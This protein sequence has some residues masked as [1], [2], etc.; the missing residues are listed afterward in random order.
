MKFKKIAALLLAGVLCVSAFT[1]CGVNKNATVAT[2]GEQK[3][4]LGIAN[5]MCR[6]EQAGNDD[7][8]LSYFGENAW[9]QDIYGGG[10]TIQDNVKDDVMERL[11][12]YYTMSNH[13]GEYKVELTE[14][15]KKTISDTASAFISANSQDA[16]EELGATQPIVEEMLTLATIRDKMYDAITAEAD[17][18]VSDEE[19]N[20][21]AYTM[22]EMK[23]D[24][25]YDDDYNYVEYT[26]AEA[27][28]IKARAE[29]VE[30]QVE[31]GKKLEKAAEKAEFSTTTGTYG[32]ND[33]I[34][35]EDLKAAMDKLKEGE[36][37]SLISTE[38]G[39]YMVRI[40]SD[41]DKE[42]T[43][44]NRQNII[45]ERKETL[46]NDKLEEWQKSDGWK[47]K[48]SALEKIQFRNHFTQVSD[49]PST[50]TAETVGTEAVEVP[51]TELA[52]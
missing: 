11:H 31:A 38:S 5:F 47:I 14:E 9:S 26:Q 48:E 44:E 45:K 50:E 35:E 3:I 6:Y 32:A 18:D 8:Y 2:L 34:L 36:T 23:T 21:R 27:D 20:M 29:I 24:G 17:T 43:E 16:L 30:T 13:A 46:Y 22:V 33:D 42:A 25:Y 10:E 7:T 4:S 41:T 40:D 12:E 37:S 51:T 19:A 52:E 49:T 15:E 39:Y 28:A 1:G